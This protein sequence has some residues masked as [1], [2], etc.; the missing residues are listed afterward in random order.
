MY[1]IYCSKIKCK[2]KFVFFNLKSFGRL[3]IHKIKDIV[4]FNF[5]IYVV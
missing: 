3:V 5:N 4:Y 2:I 1:T